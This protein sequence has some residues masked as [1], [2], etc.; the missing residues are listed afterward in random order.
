MIFLIKHERFYMSFVL[1][2]IYFGDFGKCSKP[3]GK[4]KCCMILN[5]RFELSAENSKCRAPHNEW[6]NAWAKKNGFKI[7]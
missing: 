2:H 4:E 6:I 5:S 7:D 3:G 1:T